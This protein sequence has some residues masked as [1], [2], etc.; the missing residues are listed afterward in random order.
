MWKKNLGKDILCVVKLIKIRMD[1]CT[2]FENE[3]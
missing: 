3:F 1:S 2:F